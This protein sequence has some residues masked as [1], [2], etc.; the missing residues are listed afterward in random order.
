MVINVISVQITTFVLRKKYRTENAKKNRYSH[1]PNIEKK[2][3][4]W[5]SKAK[6]QKLLCEKGK[7]TYEEFCNW[8]IE[9]KKWF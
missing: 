7:I 3:Q 4:T 1:I 2:F 6:V 5:Y 9:N 8:F